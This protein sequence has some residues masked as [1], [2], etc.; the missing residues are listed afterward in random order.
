MTDFSLHRRDR[1]R[2]GGDLLLFNRSDI[3]QRRRYDLESETSH[4]IE[5]MIIG[6]RQ[7]KAEFFLVSALKPHPLPKIVF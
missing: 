1:E 3:P 4:G 6:T 2:R 5:I 7:L